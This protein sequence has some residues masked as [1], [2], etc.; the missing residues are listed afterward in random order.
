MFSALSP[1]AALD[2][3]EVFVSLKMSKISKT[4]KIS[5]MSKMSKTCTTSK[6]SKNFQC[7]LTCR[8]SVSGRSFFKFKDE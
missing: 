3:E 6:M 2:L 4:S 8:C 5:K 7:N 1:V